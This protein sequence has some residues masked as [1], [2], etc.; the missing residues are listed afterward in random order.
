MGNQE[1]LSLAKE[2]Q[3]LRPRFDG[4]YWKHETTIIWGIPEYEKFGFD[5]S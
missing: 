2:N 1:C 3:E 5:R 4:R